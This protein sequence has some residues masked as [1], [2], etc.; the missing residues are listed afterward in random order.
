MSNFHIGHA[1]ILGQ[2]H[3]VTNPWYKCEIWHWRWSDTIAH[4]TESLTEGGICK[5][6]RKWPGDSTLCSYGKIPFA[7]GTVHLI[8]KCHSFVFFFS[9][10][11]ASLSWKHTEPWNI[12]YRYDILLYLVTWLKWRHCPRQVF[13]CFLANA[14]RGF[15]VI[16][17]KY[18]TLQ[19]LPVR[20]INS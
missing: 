3:T 19:S 9:W 17:R 13:I 15:L 6:W 1:S 11:L 4:I 8:K 10:F 16:D 7:D 18:D 20:I 14:R 5:F 12:W 2:D